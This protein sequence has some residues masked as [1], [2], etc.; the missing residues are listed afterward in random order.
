MLEN[1]K[2]VKDLVSE[3]QKW[4]KVVENLQNDFNYTKA[5]QSK[6]IDTLEISVNSIG[7]VTLTRQDDDQSKLL[8]YNNECIMKISKE[9]ENIS[10][11]IEELDAKLKSKEDE[12]SKLEATMNKKIEGMKRDM[13]RRSS[14]NQMK[15]KCPNCDQTFVTQT[16]VEKHIEMMHE[17]QSFKCSKCYAIFLSEWRL[18][19]H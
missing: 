17:K 1:I 14:K 13:V 11:R 9:K 12:I 15:T 4:L 7:N 8:K 2:S 18:R 16:E 3:L 6:K 5:V 19:K 10:S